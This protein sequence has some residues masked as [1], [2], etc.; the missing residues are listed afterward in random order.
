VNQL[1]LEFQPGDGWSYNNTRYM[2]LTSIV[3]QVS[4]LIYETFLRE[5]FFSPLD[6]SVTN[7]NDPR[8]HADGIA[9]GYV[10]NNDVWQEAEKSS[11]SK[12]PPGPGS[13][14]SAMSDLLRWSAALTEGRLL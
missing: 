4:G 5:R 9:K 12:D 1:P 2:M 13:T 8:D 6:M 3:K 11:L 10:F 7:A 14:L